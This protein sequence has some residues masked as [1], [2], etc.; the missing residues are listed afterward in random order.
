MTTKT[1]GAAPKKGS[2]ARPS[3]TA[4]KAL[5]RSF[6]QQQ[7]TV[8]TRDVFL[9]SQG[10]PVVEVYLANLDVTVLMRR[11]DLLD[12]ARRG[13]EYYPFRSAIYGMIREGGLSAAQLALDGLPDTLDLAARVA[14][15]AIVASPP[16]YV[17]AAEADDA[18]FAPMVDAWLSEIDQVDTEVSAAKADL[19]IATEAHRMLVL[20][21]DDDD[22]KA[23]RRTA[24]N[25]LKTARAH[26]AAL[27]SKA[28]ALRLVPPARPTTRTAPVL[29]SLREE[30]LHP[31]FVEPGEDPGPDQVVLRYALPDDDGRIPEATG[32]G[33]IPPADLV[34]ILREAHRHGPGALGRRFRGDEPE[35]PALGALR[36]LAGGR[37]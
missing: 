16:E 34:T 20:A 22:T 6:A 27:K 4:G 3:T 14:L 7:R 19:D 15:S 18:E 29:A 35:A 25:A 26:H 8:L 28:D 13:A 12:L 33:G 17:E 9:R 31:L 21:G 10:P 36:D 30:D 37:A 11:L 24:E 1:G 23:R 2:P 5:L 32:E